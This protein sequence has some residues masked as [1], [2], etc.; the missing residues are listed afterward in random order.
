MVQNSLKWFYA[1][2]PFFLDTLLV[3]FSQFL[4]I[5]KHKR[6][7]TNFKVIFLQESTIISVLSIVGPGA[8]IL[9]HLCSVPWYPHII[10]HA[11]R[12]KLLDQGYSFPSDI[13]R[14]HQLL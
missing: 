4:V 8:N 9:M 14:G 5:S 3:F 1:P 7:R 11:S 13:V 2:G 12:T 6:L 10:H